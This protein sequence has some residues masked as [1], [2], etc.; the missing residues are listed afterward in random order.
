MHI[1]NKNENNT[2]VYY[3][4][5]CLNETLTL[6]TPFEDPGKYLHILEDLRADI[7]LIH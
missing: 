4:Y 7:H 2:T 5:V 6:L 1:I 3:I